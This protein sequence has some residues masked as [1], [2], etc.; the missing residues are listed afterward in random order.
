MLKYLNLLF[1][2]LQCYSNT[3]Y[4]VKN[5]SVKSV[6][7]I[8]ISP[9]RLSIS[10]VIKKGKIYQYYSLLYVSDPNLYSCECLNNSFS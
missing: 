3:K 10:N 9:N 4:F 8:L 5:I 2:N 6:P 7:S 1:C